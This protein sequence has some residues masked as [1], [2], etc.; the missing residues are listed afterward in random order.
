M[1]KSFISAIGLT[2]MWTLSVVSAKLIAIAE[3]MY[4]PSVGREW[5]V[6]KMLATDLINKD[7]LWFKLLSLAD[8]MT[9]NGSGRDAYR[10][11]LNIVN[12]FPVTHKY[13]E[14]RWARNGLYFECTNCEQLNAEVS[15]Y[16][17]NC[18]AKMLGM[19]E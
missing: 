12:T 4:A 2:A 1:K 14:A 8:D 13:Y 11:C 9:I 6:N 5:T 17:P 19:E 3:K 16:C 7:D 18:G 15:K 10:H